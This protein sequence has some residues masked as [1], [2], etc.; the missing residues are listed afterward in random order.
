METLGEGHV[1]RQ[2]WEGRLPRLSGSAWPMRPTE[3]GLDGGR[4]NGGTGLANRNVLVEQLRTQYQQSGL[5]CPTE[6]DTLLDP[7]VKTVT[8]GHQLCLAGG[9]AFVVYKIR[10]AM[11][12]AESLTERW[13]TPVVPV[14]WLAS[15]DHDF[16]E[17]QSV[18]D[19]ERHHVWSSEEAGGAVGR[20]A[21]QPAADTVRAWAQAVGLDAES[22]TAWVGAC[23]GSLSDAMRR[24]VHHWMGADGIVVVDGDAPAFK[25]AFA[26]HMAQEIAE[27]VLQREVTQVNVQLEQAG[28]SPQVHVRETNLFHLSDRRRERIRRTD[29]GWFAGDRHWASEADL[30]SELHD[31]PEAFSPNALLRPLY[32]SFLLPDVAVVGG[33]AEVS[34]WLQLTTA[35]SAFGLSQPVPVPRDAVRT[36]GAADMEVL[37]RIGWPPDSL[38]GT[39]Q[40]WEARWM[41]EKNPPDAQRWREAIDGQLEAVKAA[42]A[43][44]DA[45]LVGSVEATRAQMAKALDK[46]DV[47]GR[48]AIRRLAQEELEALEQLHR[49]LNPEGK[50]QERVAN[51]HGL[52]ARWTHPSALSSALASTFREGHGGK[53]WRPVLHTVMEKAV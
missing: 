47:R 21:A 15:E 14:F 50:P 40:D 8:T 24:W 44:V 19:G 49:A 5:P 41:A 20:M 22:M 46:L 23:K 27:G 3:E 36:L 32:Q 35:Y 53:D 52:A 38:G 37:Q 51:L 11:A 25:A 39:V 17:I 45:S 30:L 42:F 18:W 12:L 31:R 26:K 2:W 7:A 6:V 4:P 29:A 43:A 10:T 28:H 16:E 34:Y 13:G 48:R 1:V 9:P 33:L